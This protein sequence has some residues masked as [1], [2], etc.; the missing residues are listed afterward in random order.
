MKQ[1]EGLNYRQKQLYEN[2]AEDL[3]WVKAEFEKLWQATFPTL[4][5][6]KTTAP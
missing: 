4:P 2:R 1:T 5:K 6:P 3:A